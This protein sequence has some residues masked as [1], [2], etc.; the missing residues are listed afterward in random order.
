MKETS[1]GTC[2][3]VEYSQVGSPCWR[4]SF[5][6]IFG[7][8]LCRGLT[9]QKP[10]FAN[11]HLAA[12]VRR[13]GVS[14]VLL[15]QLLGQERYK[16]LGSI[17]QARTGTKRSGKDWEG[18]H[19]RVGKCIKVWRE[20]YRKGPKECPIVHS[21]LLWGSGG[22]ILSK[23]TLSYK[24]VFICES[25]CCYRLFKAPSFLFS[26]TQGRTGLLKDPGVAKKPRGFIRGYS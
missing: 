9:W 15:S 16:D 24:T 7:E 4:S 8:P 23:C 20:Q 11:T 14:R 25:S 3:V 6:E 13:N 26:I 5:V 12:L 22:V 19:I 1:I 2:L 18:R 17:R 10:F 21:E